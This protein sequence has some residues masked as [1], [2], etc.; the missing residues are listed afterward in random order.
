[1]VFDQMFFS[2]CQFFYSKSLFIWIWIRIPIRSGFNN[3]LDLDP[4]SANYGYPDPDSVNQDPKHC[5]KRCNV[6]VKKICKKIVNA[7]QAQPEDRGWEEA[8]D[9][10][11]PRGQAHQAHQNLL[12]AVTTQFLSRTFSLLPFFVSILVLFF[13][14]IFAWIF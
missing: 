11:V 1:M 5:F 12:Q 10:S 6:R 4:D 8:P 7:A 14:W 9:G 13:L 2:N 3:S